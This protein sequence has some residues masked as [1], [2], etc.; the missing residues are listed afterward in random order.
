M[1]LFPFA[2]AE[3]PKYVFAAANTALDRKAPEWVKVCAV[4]TW[5]GH[6]YGT[7]VI[8]GR[9]IDEMVTNFRANP[10]SRRP[11]DWEH[12][13]LWTRDNGMPAPA[14]GWVRELERRG[15]ELWARVE[16]TEKAKAQIEAGE[17]AFLSPVL[18]FHYTDHMSGRDKGTVFHSLALTNQPFFEE[19]PPLAASAEVPMITN[20][21]LLLGLAASATTTQQ[22]ERA[23]LLVATRKAVLE[24][25]KL[26]EEA[27][28]D[29]IKAALAAQ[30]QH[31]GFVPATQLVAVTTELAELKASALVEAAQRDGKIVPAQRDWLMGFARDNHAAAEAWCK[32]APKVFP[33]AASTRQA[34]GASGGAEDK[35]AVITLTAAEEQQ[36][37]AMGATV[38]EYIRAKQEA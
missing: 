5:Q 36:R 25:L 34:P 15:D 26:P 17:Y 3:N 24:Q 7:V 31:A 20:L 18:I 16:W 6:V 4:G 28:P 35:P 21:A 9:D 8:T 37:V 11:C 32:V 33:G 38:D 27:T 2:A 23:T 13:S 22:E 30:A 12:Q 14:S 1:R 10:M 29:Q 19:L